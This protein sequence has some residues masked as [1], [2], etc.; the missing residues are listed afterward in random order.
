MVV[1]PPGDLI[2]VHAPAGN[3]LRITLPVDKVQVGW[4]IIPT[5]GAV[6]VQGTIVMI[7]WSAGESI[8]PSFTINEKV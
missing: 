3:P 4:V 5:V 6:G 7:T 1:I 2:K 8:V